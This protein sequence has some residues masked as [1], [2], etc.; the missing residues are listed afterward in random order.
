M[1]TILKLSPAQL[2][3]L[4]SA[5]MILLSLL[6]YLVLRLPVEHNYQLLVYGVFA[7][8]IAW[9]IFQAKQQAAE[10]AS[11]KMLFQTGFRVFIVVSLCMAVFTYIYFSQQAEFRDAKI[12]E[13]SALL[14]AAGNHTPAEI[15]QNEEKLREIF[16]PMMVS[17][18][19]FRYLILGALMSVVAAGF[20]QRKS[21]SK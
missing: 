4:T 16:L 2:G 1:K 15:T 9:A 3:L 8:G 14:K 12:A 5:L 13:N 18:A 7:A 19:V 11:F 17:G 21:T 10:A 20:W 6:G